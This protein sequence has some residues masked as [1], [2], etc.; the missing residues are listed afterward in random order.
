MAESKV[1]FNL[2]NVYY[3][4]LTET[5]NQGVITET[6]G[7]PKKVAGAVSIDLS[8]EGEMTP[9][10]ADGV[11]YYIAQNNQGYQGSLE[12]ARIPDSMLQDIWGMALDT[13][14]VIIE[15]VNKEYKYFA[16]LFQIDGDKDEQLYTFYK[17]SASRPN[18]ASQT[19]EESKNPQTQTL[20]LSISPLLSNGN[21]MA[22]TSA[23]TT[24]TARNSWFT[25]VHE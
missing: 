11:K 5:E 12:M 24:T 15:N 9:F 3:A 20:E 21:V 17:C 19:N 2:K 8:Q 16:L 6:F 4:I 10:Y 18:I 14:G 25:E 13:D 23:T 22:K 7:T 1:Q